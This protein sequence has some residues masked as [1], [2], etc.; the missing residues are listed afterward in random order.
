MNS[1]ND[2]F[3]FLHFDKKFTDAH[4][5]IKFHNFS[6]LLFSPH[7]NV[8]FNGYYLSFPASRSKSNIQSYELSAS[9]MDLSV[10]WD[11]PVN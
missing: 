3:L 6:D 9:V 1:L 4:N 11:K 7:R 8:A 5:D 2:I 10:H